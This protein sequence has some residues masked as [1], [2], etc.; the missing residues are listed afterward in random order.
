MRRTLMQLNTDKMLAKKEGH[1]GWMTFNNPERRNAMSLEMWEATG[2][3]MANFSADPDIRVV[4]MQGA[5]DKAFVSGADISQFEKQRADAAMTEKYNARAEAGRSAIRD[6]DRP[7]IAMIRG[8]CMGGGLGIAMSA[9]LRFAAEGSIFGIPAARLSIAY[10]GENIVNL[11]NLV[12]PS[13][14]KDIL[15]SARRLQADEA[16]SIGLIN[17]VLPPEELEAHTRAYCDTL[18]DN[19]PLSIKAHKVILAELSKE[20]ADQSKI[21]AVAEMC[22]N[23]ADYKEGRTAFMEKRKPVW[24]SA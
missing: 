11:F 16:L 4:V 18:A 14:A 21:D 3:I 15:Y 2:E 5:G 17:R 9:D 23:S 24:K 10:T 20:N 1:I 12:G 8:F 6:F 22:F 7:I 19:A 13:R